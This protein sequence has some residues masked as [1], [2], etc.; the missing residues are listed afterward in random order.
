MV[1]LQK[2]DLII[3]KWLNEFKVIEGELVYFKKVDI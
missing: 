3:I 2:I 1:K